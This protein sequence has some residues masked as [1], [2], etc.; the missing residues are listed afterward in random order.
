MTTTTY[1]PTFPYTAFLM[2]V[3]G[4][5]YDSVRPDETVADAIARHEQAGATVL[6]CWRWHEVARGQGTRTRIDLAEARV[7]TETPTRPQ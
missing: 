2:W 7:M 3:K 6:D 1:P 5:G 4:H